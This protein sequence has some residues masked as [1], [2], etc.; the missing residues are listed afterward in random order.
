MEGFQVY[1]LKGKL[2]SL[3]TYFLLALFLKV[4]EYRTQIQVPESIV[5]NATFANGLQNWNLN[6][7]RGFVCNSL[8]NP[9]VLPMEGKSFAVVNQRTDTWAGIAQIITDRIELETM[10]DVVATVRISGPCS[11]S[12]VRA[13][14]HIKEADNSDRYST[15]G[16]FVSQQIFVFVNSNVLST[17]FCYK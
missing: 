4:E 9:K 12:T 13:S 11:E 8:E 15:M 16:R 5:Y 2:I 14:L 1:K 7:C 10:Y 3:I 17:W 6:G